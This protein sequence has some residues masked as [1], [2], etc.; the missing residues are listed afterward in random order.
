MFQMGFLPSICVCSD[1]KKMEQRLAENGLGVPTADAPLG[2]IAAIG[3]LCVRLE[4]VYSVEGASCRAC[5]RIDF[6]NEGH[7]RRKIE[8]LERRL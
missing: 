1:A 7:L 5:G 3:C 2:G 8:T 6:S 4:E